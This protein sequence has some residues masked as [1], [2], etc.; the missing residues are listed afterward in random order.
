MRAKVI[1]SH[2]EST[3]WPER[4]GEEGREE[5]KEEEVEEEGEGG[6]EWLGGCPLFLTPPNL[7]LGNGSKKTAFS[8][9]TK[10]L[11]YPQDAFLLEL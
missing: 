8:D 2:P 3:I 9:E 11:I 6:E 1:P 7:K 5:E 4:E 10:L